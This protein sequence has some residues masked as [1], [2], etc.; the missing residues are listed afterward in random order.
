MVWL[1]AASSK[2]PRLA[3]AVGQGRPWAER[4]AGDV[5]AQVR[6]HEQDGT[7]NIRRYREAAKWIIVHG[8][9]SVAV[10]QVFLDSR[11]TYDRRR[12]DVDPDSK[13][14]HAGGERLEFLE[15]HLSAMDAIRQFNARA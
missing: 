1:R 13:R 3:S 4:L 7:G 15:Q 10:V 14:A 2:P 9:L 5:A 12:D 11:R 8:F 6:R